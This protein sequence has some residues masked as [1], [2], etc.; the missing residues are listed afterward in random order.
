MTA[1]ATRTLLSGVDP[2]CVSVDPFP[3]LVVHD[4]L[5]DELCRTLIREYPPLDTFTGGRRHGDGV[6]I[7]YPAVR[8][9]ADATTSAAWK[10]LVSAHLTREFFQDLIRVF[11]PH[12]LREYPDLETRFGPLD[13]RRIGLR[14][15]DDYSQ[16]DVLL[17]AQISVHTPV[18]GAP[19][20]DRGP[21]IKIT[22][23]PLEGFLYLRPDEDDSEGGDHE[24]FSIRPDAA[25]RFGRQQTIDRAQLRLEK[26]IP[27]RRNTLV[28]LLNSPRSVQGLSPRTASPLPLMYFN[29]LAQMREPLFALPRT[30]A[31]EAEWQ[32]RRLR[33]SAG[34]LR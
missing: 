1:M 17:D 5:D 15:R 16:H 31:G 9:L 8:S 2:G 7:H 28:V 24:I 13:T 32:M 21:H 12:L 22:D 20:A 25:P 29:F 10:A 14:R 34:A 19:C 23:K 30:V 18:T 11:R 4:A 26:R 3:H 27:Y 33:A 6:K